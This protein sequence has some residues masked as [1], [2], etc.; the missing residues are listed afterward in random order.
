[1]TVDLGLTSNRDYRP[2]RG[3]VVRAAWLVVEALVFS[4]PV[5]TSYPV[6]RW[7]LR[8]F[9]ARVGRDVI[10]KP[11]V[12][13]KYP[14]RLTVGDR[15]WLGERCWIDSMEDVVLESDVVVSQGAYVCTGNHDWSDPGMGLTP[16]PTVL[17]HGVWIAAFACVGPGRRV[18]RG[19]VVSLGAILLQDTEENGIYVGNPATKVGERSIRA[20]PGPVE[21]EGTVIA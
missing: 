19:S 7:L 2:G 3:F 6:K 20:V 13:V 9:G 8:L 21:I 5:L 18:A 16:E 14:W 10:I 17:E 1:L 12:H 4:S 15:C 11:G